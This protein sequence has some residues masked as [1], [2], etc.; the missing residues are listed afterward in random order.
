MFINDKLKQVFKIE[1][2]SK[3]R[4]QKCSDEIQISKDI[5]RTKTPKF[6]NVP[7]QDLYQESIRS[8]LRAYSNLR[9]EIGYVQG[10]NMTV[11]CIL[12][13]ICANYSEI[14]KFE[15][16]AFQ[17]FVSLMDFT[18][19]GDYYK[20]NMETISDLTTEL[21]ERVQTNL[22]DIYWHIVTTEVRL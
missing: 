4:T 1:K 17:L 10:M 11:S 19:I 5:K 22:P 15:E 3:L 18:K 20:N 21:K 13:N 6:G 12:A 16:D 14:N 9:P 7:T 2:Y 8:I